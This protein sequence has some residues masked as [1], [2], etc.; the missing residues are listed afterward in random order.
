M[1]KK[2]FV[3]L[4]SFALIQNSTAQNVGINTAGSTP[5]SSAILD[6]NTGNTFTSPNGKGL[7]IPNVAL[8]ATTDAVT[9]NTPFTSLLVYNTATAGS[10]S[11][12]VSPGFYYWNGTKWVTF[13]GPGSND[14]AL[15]GNAGTTAGT[16][17]LGTTDA[18]DLVFKTGATEYMRM[19]SSGRIG[20]NNTLPSDILTVNVPSGSTLNAITADVTAG[21]GT[22]NALYAVSDGQPNYSAIFAQSSPTAGGSGF[23]IS[24]SNHTIA[25]QVNNNQ[26]Y[27]FA[28]YG[29]VVAAPAPSGGVLGYYGASYWGALGYHNAAGTTSYG[30]YFTTAACNGCATTG[31]VASSGAEATSGVGIGSYGNLFGGWIRGDVYGLALKGERA[32]LYVDGKTIVN[33]P[34]V[35]LTRTEDDQTLVNYTPASV[36]ADLQLHGVTKMEKG[37]ARV[38]LDEA[39]LGQ[40]T[41]REELTIIATPAGQTNGIYAQLTGNELLI[42]EN[43]NGIADVKVSWIIIGKRNISEDYVPAELKEKGFDKTLHEFM[44]NENNTNVTPPALWWDGKKLNKGTIP[45]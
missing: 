44:H 9:V 22:G 34:I 25:G 32:S 36:T 42:K 4:I 10:G 26:A 43:N 21:N 2:L 18:V 28:V 15:L 40:F 37:V 38:S 33:Q 30:G 1:M 3:L 41:S 8:T 19:T 5:N 12:A 45:R 24:T 23:T 31:R 39:V 27:S 17:F 11:T 7:I 20:I 35:Q 14:W 13:T 16:N 6:L 29:R